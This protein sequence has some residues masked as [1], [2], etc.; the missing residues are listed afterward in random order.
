MST[1][2]SPE[3]VQSLAAQIDAQISSLSATRGDSVQFGSKAFGLPPRPES[4]AIELSAPY[5]LAEQ[6]AE[7]E[8]ITQEKPTRFLKKFRKA[9]KQDICEEGGVLNAQWQRWKDLASAD[10]V[11][12]FGPVL[13]AMGFSGVLLE[14]LVVALGVTVI[15]IGLK[16]FC[17]EFKDDGAEMGAGETG[18]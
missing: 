10:V 5:P 4:S 17:E 14:S 7:I 8:R 9:A 2:F 3:T 11:K 12:S 6:V 1:S 13:V 16:A 18:A 15:H